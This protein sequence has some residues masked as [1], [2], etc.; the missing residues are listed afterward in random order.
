MRSGESDRQ[1]LPNPQFLASLL[2]SHRLLLSSPLPNFEFLVTG[3]ERS[4]NERTTA[5]RS[6]RKGR[7]KLFSSLS[8][9]FFSLHYRI[10]QSDFKLGLTE[11]KQPL[12]IEI[13]RLIVSCHPRFNPSN[14]RNSPLI[15][16]RCV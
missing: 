12:N 5:A 9:Q 3:S 8:F 10:F 16:V 6:K 15:K 1:G 14:S 2:P 13:L 7:R 11:V 4:A